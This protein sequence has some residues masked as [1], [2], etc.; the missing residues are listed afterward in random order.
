[1]PAHITAL[2]PFLDEDQLT[3]VA[4]S[5]LRRLCAE[6]GPI[7]VAFKGLGRFSDT[8]YFDPDPAEPF[9]ELT[10]AIAGEWPSHKP[11]GGAFAEVIPT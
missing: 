2:S 3:P 11:Y 5:R 10:E 1:M 8:V 7:A 6:R 4:L 9:S